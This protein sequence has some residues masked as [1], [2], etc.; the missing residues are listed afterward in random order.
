MRKHIK[1][2]KRVYENPAATEAEV[3]NAYWTLIEAGPKIKLVQRG[4]HKSA[5]GI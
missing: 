3:E 1:M 2:Q 4:Y 5:G